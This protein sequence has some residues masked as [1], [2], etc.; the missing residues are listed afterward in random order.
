MLALWI[1]T[2]VDRLCD[3][4]PAAIPGNGQA[5]PA[6]PVPVRASVDPILCLTLVHIP[7]LYTFWWLNHERRVNSVSHLSLCPSSLIMV[8]AESHHDPSY[9]SSQAVEVDSGSEL[10]RYSDALEDIRDYLSLHLEAP[11]G[12]T[13]QLP[14]PQ[15]PYTSRTSLLQQIYATVHALGMR[16]STAERAMVSLSNPYATTSTTAKVRQT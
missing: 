11:F 6:L 13:V 3:S 1:A 16:A 7:S 5:R 12:S 10:M 9:T 14:L 8:Q 4:A 2:A 15:I